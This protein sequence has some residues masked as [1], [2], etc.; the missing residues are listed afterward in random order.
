MLLVRLFT[1][2]MCKRSYFQTKLNTGDR[3]NNYRIENNIGHRTELGCI[4]E[5]NL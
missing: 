5:K 2:K 4:V 3:V 1:P